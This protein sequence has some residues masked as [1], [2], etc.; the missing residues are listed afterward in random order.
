MT[1]IPKPR[2]GEYAL[3]RKAAKR[4]LRTDEAKHKAE[5]KR[6]DGYACRAPH[7]TRAEYEACRRLRIESCHLTHK[8]MGGDASGVRSETGLLVTLGLRCHRER[9]DGRT[10]EGPT[11]R[12]QFR[13]F[14]QRADGLLVWIEK[15]AN[16]WRVTH[17]EERIGDANDQ[18]KR[19]RRG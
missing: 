18:W 13:N 7:T 6:R 8:G 9:L 17:T 14:D 12:V 4:T 11:L 16:F 10:G 1:A 19:S 3:E 2:A 15:F 5:S